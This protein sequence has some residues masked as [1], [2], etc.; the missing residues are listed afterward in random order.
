MMELPRLVEQRAHFV[1][2]VC[3]G[4]ACHRIGVDLGVGQQ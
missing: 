1:V 3:H 4:L 2:I